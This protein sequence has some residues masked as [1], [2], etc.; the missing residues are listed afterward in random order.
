[1]FSPVL[2]S[3]PLLFHSPRNERKRDRS[4][5]TARRHG[6][7]KKKAKTDKESVLYTTFLDQANSLVKQ[8]QEQEQGTNLR[9]SVTESSDA[10]AE[11]ITATSVSSSS[12]IQE[13][14]SD[15]SNWTFVSPLTNLDSSSE[16][17]TTFISKS[18]GAA[19]VAPSTGASFERRTTTADN[20]KI[21]EGPYPKGLV[22]ALD[23]KSLPIVSVYCA[24]C[25]T[26]SNAMIVCSICRAEYYCS[27]AC[28][29]KDAIHF[30][31]ICMPDRVLLAVQRNNVM[32]VKDALDK[33]SSRNSHDAILAFQKACELGWLHIVKL[34]AEHKNGIDLAWRLSD[35]YNK[36]LF[37]WF[38]DMHY[39]PYSFNRPI[40]QHDV[41]KYLLGRIP[42]CDLSKNIPI[43]GDIPLFTAA[44][45]GW[46]NLIKDL[47]KQGTNFFAV[48]YHGQLTM[49]GIYHRSS[50]VRQKRSGLPIDLFQAYAKQSNVVKNQEEEGGRFINLNM[51]LDY[52]IKTVK[53]TF[54]VKQ[55]CPWP[56]LQ[57]VLHP[58]FVQG[59]SCKDLQVFLFDNI[60]RILADTRLHCLEN[61][62]KWLGT[63]TFLP[64]PLDSETDQKTKRHF[65]YERNAALSRQSDGLRLLSWACCKQTCSEILVILINSGLVVLDEFPIEDEANVA[66]NQQLDQDAVWAQL[67][68][69]A[70]YMVPLNSLGALMEQ[71]VGRAE[72]FLDLFATSQPSTDNTPVVDTFAT[73]RKLPDETKTNFNEYK[74]TN[75]F[76]ILSKSIPI[77]TEPWSNSNT[78]SMT[79]DPTRYML[80]GPLEVVLLAMCGF[81]PVNIRNIPEKWSWK[82]IPGDVAALRLVELLASSGGVVG[83]L[84]SIKL[85]AINTRE[86]YVQYVPPSTKTVT[87]NVHGWQAIRTWNTGYAK[88]ATS[89]TDIFHAY[90]LV[91]NVQ[92]I[93]TS[94]DQRWQTATTFANALI[95]YD[96]KEK[97][98][99]QA[100]EQL[101][102]WLKTRNISSIQDLVRKHSHH[103][104]T[105]TIVEAAFIEFHQCDKCKEC[106]QPRYIGH[107]K[108]KQAQRED[109]NNRKCLERCPSCDKYN[110][111]DKAFRRERVVNIVCQDKGLYMTLATYECLHCKKTGLLRCPSCGQ[112]SIYSIRVPYGRYL[113]CKRAYCQTRFTREHPYHAHFTQSDKF[114]SRLLHLLTQICP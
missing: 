83:T 42:R 77:G 28:L 113:E 93:I 48:T 71:A 32:D 24:R 112:L 29:Q 53:E 1:M 86:K 4:S 3:T 5:H 72:Q 18:N 38:I 12:S 103:F 109:L 91:K 102:A 7:S 14:W 78:L 92:G 34:I 69:H 108:T 62:S 104:V 84:A 85:L 17:E 50:D 101:Q 41:Y 60:K 13:Y 15:P 30:E 94:Y 8:P 31:T 67:D 73:L 19:V 44:R 87:R 76:H 59:D 100:R 23:P 70:Q 110:P 43:V 51:L 98:V 63:Q 56:L 20:V 45:R 107:Y 74:P 111:F 36:T 2:I 97:R 9:D 52:A 95:I 65:N 49:S 39:E 33:L 89:M 75:D 21:Q 66:L 55:P 27:D 90:G 79:R 26:I 54:Q 64:N 106:P 35:H 25:H 88:F 82:W 57:Y 11:T 99:N 68:Q 22:I 81:E 114:C 10:K 37:H 58:H 61:P 47:C 40:D 96:D 46:M 105:S 80:H 6:P 16:Y